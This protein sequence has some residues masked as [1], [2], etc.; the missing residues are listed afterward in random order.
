MR[1]FL[2]RAL[3]GVLPSDPAASDSPDNDDTLHVFS[4]TQLE[5]LRKAFIPVYYHPQ[6][7]RVEHQDMIFSAGQHSVIDHIEKVL[8]RQRRK[9][10][11]GIGSQIIN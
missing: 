10:L 4:A 9:M 8:L 3:G 1:K 5:Q 11:N 7:S 6:H 2:I